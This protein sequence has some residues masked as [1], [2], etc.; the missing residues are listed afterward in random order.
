MNTGSPGSVSKS[1]LQKKPR[2]RII[3]IETV[4]QE[5]VDENHS[6]VIDLLSAGY[7]LEE[8]IDAVERCE[9]NDPA[10]TLE[11]AMEYLAELPAE[12]GESDLFPSTQRHLSREDSQDDII[13]EW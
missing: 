3:N 2:S 1:P 8:S 12:D 6:V 10:R 7:S 13:M 11:S 4:I 5:P 9:T